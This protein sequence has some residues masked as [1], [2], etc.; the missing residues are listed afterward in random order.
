MAFPVK[1]I[2]DNLVL[3]QDGEWYAYYELLPY[4]YAF[5]SPD[6]K[7]MLRE[8]FRRVVAAN[9]NGKLHALCISSE[10]SVR[11]RQEAC[12]KHVSGKL[13]ELAFQ[14]IDVE[15][16]NL[17]G[18]MQGVENEVTYRFFLGFK[19][20]RRQ[21]E[22]SFKRI[23]ETAAMAVSDFI[24]DVNHNLMGDFVS[25]SD[26]EIE[27]YAGMEK[28][29]YDRIKKHFR[30]QRLEKKDFG[31]II[32][33]IYGQQKT[34]YYTYAYDFP[35]ERVGKKTLLRKYDILRLTRCLLEEHQKHIRIAREEGDSYVAY[36]TVNALIGELTF[37]SSEIFYYQQ[38]Q[39]GFDFPVDVSMNVEI[40]PNVNALT[41]V[42]NKKKEL[43]DLDEHAYTSGND[44]EDSVIDALESVDELEQDLGRTKESM[45]KLSYV[46]RVAAETRELLERRVVMVRD[47]YEHTFNMKLVRPF[48]DMTGLHEEFVPAGKRYLNDYIQYVK[49]DFLSSLGFGASR[50]LGEDD[51][52]FIGY[53]PETGRNTYIDPPLAAQGVSGS[54]TNSLAMSFTG[55]L[56]GGKSMLANN[57]VYH[58]A[59]YGAKI[60]VIDPKSER[61]NWKRDLPELEDEIQIVSLTNSKEDRG[62]LDPYAIMSNKRDAETLALDIL[63]FLTGT[64]IMEGKKF[65]LLKR[66]VRGV[67]ERKDSGLL[68]VIDELRAIGGEEAE[69]LAEHIESF[70]DYDFAGLLFSDGH[71]RQQIDMEKQINVIQVQNLMLPE[72]GKEP[73][74]YTSMECLSIAMMIVISTFAL[75]FIYSDRNIYKVV[76]F[77]EAWSFLQVPQGKA[78]GN[79]LARAGR[80]MQAGVYF[81]T[82]SCADFSDDMKNNIGLKFAFRSTDITEIKN[83]L[84]YFGLDAEDEGNQEMV[85]NLQNGE[86]LMMDLYGRVG[87]IKVQILLRHVYVAFDTRPVMQKEVAQ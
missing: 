77:D 75:K 57:I 63:T 21:E 17:I 6:E 33:H 46:V 48:G 61:G 84:K 60:L 44:T 10:S 39:S 23:K 37:P 36:L 2:E 16:E 4:N 58:E 43:K 19:L 7:L 5:L 3:N 32:E 67:S 1:Y 35:T 72:R 71:A 49:A 11:E 24:R 56:G 34:P 13:K 80:S 9:R 82:Q 26:L 8:R 66:A 47:Y 50:I 29:L 64:S 28:L 86:C 25:I 76:L 53:D 31:Y 41:T 38:A 42:R 83:I 45:Y 62:T 55:T 18:T 68:Y 27:R 81:V 30:F 15:T 22:I 85:R 54:V 51:G 70:T 87:K 20:V 74:S 73:S 79:Q 78:L 52:A 14:V 69:L 65:S 59:L 40:V 12:K